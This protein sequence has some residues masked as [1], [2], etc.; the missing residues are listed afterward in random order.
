MEKLI[1][2]L[3]VALGNTFCMYF[4]THS[5][6]WNVEGMH[7]PQYHKFFKKVYEDLYG[8]IDPMSEQ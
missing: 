7:F 8:A 2:T 1:A 3:K 4:K 6:H 5:Y